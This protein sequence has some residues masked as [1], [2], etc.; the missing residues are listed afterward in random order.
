MMPNQ[1]LIEDLSRQW[2]QERHAAAQ[3]QGWLG[4]WFSHRANRSQ[5]PR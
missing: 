5:G 2:Q 1:Y 3:E 4:R